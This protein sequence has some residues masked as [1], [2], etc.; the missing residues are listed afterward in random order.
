MTNDDA[1]RRDDK[2][3]S[4]DDRAGTQA[5]HKADEVEGGRTTDQL[6]AEIDSGQA[7]DKSAHNDPAAAPLGA[8]A[9]AGG[10][11]TPREDIAEA[12]RNETRR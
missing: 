1:A 11:S 6:R 10:R 12:R 5:R 3:V 4:A 9:E 7:G 8:D 2:S